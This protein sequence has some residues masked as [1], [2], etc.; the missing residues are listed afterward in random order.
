MSNDTLNI[1]FIGDIIGEPGLKVIEENIKNFIHKYKIHFIIANGENISGG[2]GLLEKD[3][4]K[5]FEI[6][7]NVLTG[8]NHTFSKMQSNKY[9]SEEYRI[10][11]PAN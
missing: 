9:I 3:A 2:K 1:L 11:R 8:G 5:A 7:I 10:L 6:G 4:K